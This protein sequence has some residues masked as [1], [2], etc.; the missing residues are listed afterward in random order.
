MRNPEIDSRKYAQL[1]LDNDAKKIQ[2][3][4]GI[5]SNKRYQSNWTSRHTK[6]ELK[7]LSHT[8]HSSKLK[9][10]HRLQCKNIKCLG[11]K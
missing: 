11:K 2:W 8:F 6:N 4:K 1:T 5:L 10:H 7:P 9:M 3:S